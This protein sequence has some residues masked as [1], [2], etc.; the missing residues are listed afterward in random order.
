MDGEEVQPTNSTVYLG[1][2]FDSKLN[3]GPHILKKCDKA[4]GH[5]HACKRAVGKQW[6]ISPQGI[7]WLYN[8]VILPSVGYSA[9]AWQHSIERKLYLRSRLEGLQR[10]AALMVTR[11]LNSSPTAN[12][13]IIA[14]LQPINLR[15]KQ[16]AIKSALRIKLN[17]LWNKNYQ[18]EHGGTSKSHAYSVETMLSKIPFAGCRITDKIQS[19]TIIDRRFRVYIDSRIDAMHHI[20]QINEQ[21]WQVYTDVGRARLVSMP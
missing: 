3:W 21:T 16:L 8:Q 14:G 1:V 6:G 2:T 10:H 17:G 9:F 13:E 19:T 5:L 15:L 11:G 12:L 18:F 7:K 4:I 20:E